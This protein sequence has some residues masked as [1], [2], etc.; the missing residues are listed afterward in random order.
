MGYGAS[1]QILLTIK[2]WESFWSLHA[3]ISSAVKGILKCANL[4]GL[5]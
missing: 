3:S 2:V 1:V 4:V 5:K